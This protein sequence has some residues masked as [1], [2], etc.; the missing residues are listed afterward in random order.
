MPNP[1]QSPLPPHRPLGHRPPPLPPSAIWPT[2]DPATHA[3][4]LAQLSRMVRALV[5]PPAVPPP[6]PSGEE[7]ARDTRHVEDQR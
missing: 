4:A 3:A 7:A 6:M 5:P 1:L 2:L